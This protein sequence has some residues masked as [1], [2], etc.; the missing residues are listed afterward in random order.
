MLALHGAGGNEHLFFEG[1]GLGLVLREAEKRGWAV[2]APRAEAGLA[3]VGG[4]LEAAK[5]LLPVDPGRI[6]LMGHS[7]GGAHSFSAIAQFPELFRAVAIFAGAGQPTQVP[8]DLPIMMVVGEQELSRLK[9][10]IENAYRRLQELNI[11]TLEYKKYEGCEHLMIVR[12]ALP[13]AFAFFERAPQRNG[14]RSL[15]RNAAK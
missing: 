12:E 2:I 3:H 14:K 8:P 4:V 15:Q 1:Y 10:S 6:Y 5:R 13:D 7:M 11:K 9:T